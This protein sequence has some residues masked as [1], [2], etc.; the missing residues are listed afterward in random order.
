MCA[1]SGQRLRSYTPIA[2]ARHS[3]THAVRALTPCGECWLAQPDG[4][5][6]L[7]ELETLDLEGCTGLEK[8]PQAITALTCLREINVKQCPLIKPAAVVAD[9]SLAPVVKVIG[10][11]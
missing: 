8:L 7:I 1:H 6:H 3:R 10:N 9:L 5:R 4:L 2:L 11:E